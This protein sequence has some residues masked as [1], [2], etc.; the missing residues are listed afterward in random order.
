MKRREFITLI[1]GAAAG[2]LTARAQ[3]AGMPVVGF[4]GVSSLAKTGGGVLLDFKRGLAETGFVE[5]RNVAI[6]YRW[7]DDHYDRL[8][9][10]AAELV[11]RQVAVLAA[12][13]SPAALPAKAATS[14]IPTVFMIGSDP[15]KLGL[16][17]S[18]NH[19]GGNLTGVSY[20]NEE[21]APKR[22]NLLHELIPTAKTIALLVNPA[23]ATTATEQTREMQDAVDALSLRLMVVKASNPIELEDAF[24]TLVQQR[25]EAL[26]LSVDPLFGNH[27]DQIVA[28][29]TRGKIPTIYPWR[30]F[31]VAGGLM[32]YGASIPDAYHQVGVYAGQI[33]R[34][35]RPAELPV[36]R[37]TKLQLVLN[38]KAAKA[39][40]LTFPQSLLATAD[41]V[42][43]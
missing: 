16:V 36:Q 24:A 22:L 37:P 18:L 41:E 34:G 15:V 29:A 25:I 8:P 12:P 40:G 38:L 14:V 10:L 32:N 3:Q 9:A 11:Q 42:I 6:E 28:L 31:T 30:E 26:Q 43:E 1:G 20:F 23:N 21:I 17:S 5:D 13:G 2:P 35:A 27:V 33:L 19:P 4:L 7:A 39:L